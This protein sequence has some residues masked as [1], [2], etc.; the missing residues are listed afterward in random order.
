MNSK[1]L[2]FD[3]ETRPMEVY[4]WGLGEQH[5]SYE[6]IV[7]D[8]SVLSFAAKWIGEK[9]VYYE[10]QRN[11]KN[12]NNDKKLLQKLWNLLD[13]ADIVLTQNGKNF[14][15]KKV[16]ARFIKHKMRPPSPYKHIDTLQIARKVAAFTSN[17]LAYTTQE[18]NTKFKKLDHGKFP[19]LKMW[20]ECLDGN[21]EAWNEM[22]RYNIHD[23]LALEEYYDSIKAWDS[24]VN[25]SLLGSGCRSCGSYKIQ[26]RGFEITSAGKQQRYQCQD[27]G[28]WCKD[29]T[30]LLS[31]EERSKIKRKI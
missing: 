17:K 24:S 25:V 2:V 12:V 7:K 22:K 28:A 31:K 30:N 3:I 26:S 19:G 6:Q 29:S 20:I 16:N 23:V 4:V 15:S 13:E 18:L 9:K 21:L 5:V 14:D 27:C 8:W 10:D 1:I 11:S